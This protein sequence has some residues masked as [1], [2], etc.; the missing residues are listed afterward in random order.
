MPTAICETCGKSFEFTKKPR[1][2][3]PR[4]CSTECRKEGLRLYR[5]KWRHDKKANDK[6]YYAK[7]AEAQAI[8]RKRRRADL[9]RMAMDTI[10]KDI[11]EA[12]K[13]DEI[14]AILEERCR[15]KSA[16]VESFRN[17]AV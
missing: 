7:R 1:G 10:L 14:K 2:R 3:N 12:K 8:V 5:L 15:I 9:N 16:Y 11:A 17:G 4:Y 13:L 6:A